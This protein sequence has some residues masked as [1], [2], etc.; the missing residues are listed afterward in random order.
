MASGSRLQAGTALAAK[1]NG[2]ANQQMRDQ[3][4]VTLR[5]KQINKSLG[6]VGVVVNPT[7]QQKVCFCLC[8]LDKMKIKGLKKIR[9]KHEFKPSKLTSV[10]F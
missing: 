9:T 4:S 7:D 5:F 6:C 10:E 2:G 1:D 8:L 3:S